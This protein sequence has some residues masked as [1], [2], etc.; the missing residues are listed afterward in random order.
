MQ[1]C[2]LLFIIKIFWF[3]KIQTTVNSR[4]MI[5]SVPFTSSSFN[6]DK[7]AVDSV[8]IVGLM[9]A[10]KF[11]AFLIPNKPCSGL[12]LDQSI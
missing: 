9:L 7:C 4:T 5:K 10:N 6:G 1:V 11:N 3:S 8:T 2:Q 12:F